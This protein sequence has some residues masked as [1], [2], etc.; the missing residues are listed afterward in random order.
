MSRLVM[1]L[2][3]LVLVVAAIAEAA[4][5]FLV[6]SEI[7]AAV[8]RRDP[9]A[10]DVSATLP[11]PL[12]PSL[13]TT[14]TIST[15][16]V[17]ARQVNLGPLTADRVTAVATR[18]HLDVASSFAN[19]RAQVT[20]IDRIDLTV[21]FTQDEASALLPAGNKFVFGDGTVT[22]QG[23]A[24]SI[25]GRFRLE[26]PAKIV[27]GIVGSSVPGLSALP[28]ISFPTQPLASCLQSVTLA[29]GTLTVTC[30]ESN[31]STDLLPHR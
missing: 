11:I 17:S 26:P 29:P 31:P 15:V 7:A 2:V 30:A 20:H 22:L 21:T 5:H 23:P 13:L 3:V 19:R 10:R 28:A 12:L 18:V 1:R 9:S 4:S 6:R 8:S 25:T 27:F 14:H 16:S 24:T